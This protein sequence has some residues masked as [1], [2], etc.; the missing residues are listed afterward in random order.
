MAHDMEPADKTARY[1]EQFAA[2]KEL[3]P[4][5][6]DV[7]AVFQPVQLTER[8]EWTELRPPYHPDRDVERTWS[9]AVLPVRAVCL[10]LLWT[11]Y[12][13][14]RFAIVVGTLVAFRVIFLGS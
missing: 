6:P 10:F 8:P 11:T 5:D 13:W 4:H 14:Y 3:V 1:A 7:P 2:R 9:T 12:T